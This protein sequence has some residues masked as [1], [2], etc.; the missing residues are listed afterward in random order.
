MLIIVDALNELRVYIQYSDQS[1]LVF[2]TQI[3]WT[4]DDDMAS[5]CDFYMRA[6]G[7]MISS[8][9]GKKIVITGKLKQ[10]KMASKTA[11]DTKASVP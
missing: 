10:T 9:T 2:K 3:K 5:T 8:R 7:I 6:K 1:E 4:K 11:E